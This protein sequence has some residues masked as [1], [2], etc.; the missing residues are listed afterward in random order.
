MKRIVDA[1]PAILLAKIDSLELLRI[2]AEQ[3][4]IPTTVWYEIEQGG[5]E[6]SALILVAKSEWLI[7]CTYDAVQLQIPSSLGP[8]ERAVI[9]QALALGVEQVVMDD[10][11]ARRFAEQVGLKPVGTLGILLAAKLA[12]FIPSVSEKIKALESSGMYLSEAVI[13]RVLMEAGEIAEP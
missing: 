6:T 10:L 11:A 13:Q 9:E 8:G 1:S 12:G 4:L 7:E 5:D 3:V 2:G